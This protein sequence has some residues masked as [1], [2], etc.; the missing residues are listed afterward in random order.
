MLMPMLGVTPVARADGPG[1]NV[2]NSF[3]RLV[4]IAKPAVVRI[5]TIIG[6]HLTVHFANGQTVTFPQNDPNG[7]PLGLSGTGTFISAHGDILTA[8]HV[9]NPPHDTSLD[10]YLDQTAAPDVS[11]YYNQ[12]VNPGS[13]LSPDQVTQELTGGQLRSTTQYAQPTSEAYL[14]TDYTGQLNATSPQNLPAYVHSPVDRIEAQSSFNAKD[15]AIIHVSNM[16]DMPIGTIG[17]STTVQEQDELRIVGFPGN[18]DVN[19]NNISQLLTSSVNQVFV[20]SIKT[21]DSGAPLLQVGGNVEHGDSG[22]PALNS[23]GQIVGIVSF[24]TNGPGSTSFLQASASASMV[25]QQAGVNTTP[26]PF[27]KAW[28]QAFNDY[29]STTTGHWHK[30]RQEF[31]QVANQYPNFKAIAPYLTY[32]TQQAKTEKGLPSATSTAT[33]N[34]PTQNY[35]S[36]NMW[37]IVGAI[38][39]LLLIVLLVIVIALQRRRGSRLTTSPGVPGGV[40]I[41]ANGT[42]PQ[43][44]NGNSPIMPDRQTT[45]TPGVYG[46]RPPDVLRAFGA[47]PTSSWPNQAPGQPAP[48]PAPTPSQTFSG[49]QTWL[50]PKS[51]IQPNVPGSPSVPINPNNPNNSGGLVVWPCGHMNRPIARF[52]SVCGEPAP[53][54]PAN[55]QYEQ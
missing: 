46:S 37:I 24:G 30:A 4:D 50:A 14:S 47:P 7:Y 51:A 45:P 19:M 21:T 15:V 29:A 40:G 48:G 34:V 38:V 10:Q 8:D 33:S 49:D 53:V 13:P 42:M 23:S 32:A 6:G 22:G 43:P 36:L 11:N 27:E 28:S 18:G 16:N 20:S 12:N 5:I 1:G 35:S 9:I 25:A 26:G 3:V 41:G 44:W 2:T 55:R 52:C 31:Q 17:D 54:R 39:V